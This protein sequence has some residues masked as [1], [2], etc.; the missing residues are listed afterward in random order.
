MTSTRRIVVVGA[1]GS[2]KST[3]AQ[4]AAGALGLPFVELDA[5]HWG[6][7]WTP[8]LREE[9]RWR[10]QEAVS[11]ESWVLA[12]NYGSVRDLVWT[13]AETL[14]WLDYPLPL[15]AWRLLIRTLRRTLTREEL[16]N[17]NRERFRDQFLLGDSL[18]VWLLKTHPRYRR[19]YPVLF[20]EPAYAHLHVIHCRTPQQAEQWHASLS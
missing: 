19:E 7:A 9:F 1:T 10:V 11:G 6:P 14:V 5:L 8:I 15:V 18:F 17:G 16:W 20:S 12:G 13:R 3:L 2:G 4:A